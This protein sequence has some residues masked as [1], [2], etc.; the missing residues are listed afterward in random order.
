MTPLFPPSPG[1]AERRT[2]PLRRLAV[3]SSAPWGVHSGVRSALK[4]RAPRLEGSG[5]WEKEDDDTRFL[6]NAPN[7]LLP[8]KLLL[9]VFADCCFLVHSSDKG[10]GGQEGE[11]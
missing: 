5:D 11:V 4:D 10:E 8:V 2:V 6:K 1:V 9:L 3:S 7:R